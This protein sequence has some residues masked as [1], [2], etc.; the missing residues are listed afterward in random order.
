MWYVVAYFLGVLVG[1]IIV[2]LLTIHKRSGVIRVAYDE[3]GTYLSLHV[4]SINDIT[5][6]KEVT[7]G[8]VTQK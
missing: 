5:S 3:D 7:L 8:V 6:K 1:G 2:K 4:D